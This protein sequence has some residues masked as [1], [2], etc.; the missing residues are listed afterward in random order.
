MLDRIWAWTLSGV[1][2]GHCEF[3]PCRW[4][5]T[6]NNPTLA[7]WGGRYAGGAACRRHA[8]TNENLQIH[9]RIPF[10]L[11]GADVDDLHLDVF[12]GDEDAD[13]VA[14]DF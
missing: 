11:A 8:T 2:V 7:V 10:I 1:T 14:D 5:E 4:H 9:R 3:R 13:V 6:P 12:L